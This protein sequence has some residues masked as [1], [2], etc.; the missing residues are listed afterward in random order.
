MGYWYLPIDSDLLQ[1]ISCRG[2]YYIPVFIGF[3][4]EQS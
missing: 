4:F 2:H 1:A 3:S